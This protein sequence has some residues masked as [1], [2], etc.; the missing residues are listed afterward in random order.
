MAAIGAAQPEE[1][2]GEDAALHEGN[3]ATSSLSPGASLRLTCLV[4]SG[5]RCFECRSRGVYALRKID[6][7]ERIP[8]AA[9]KAEDA[10]YR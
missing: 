1:A 5:E 4:S 6:R 3:S 9:A 8:D 10:R 7:L 2:M